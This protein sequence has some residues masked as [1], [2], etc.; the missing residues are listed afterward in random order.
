[1]SVYLGFM[2]GHCSNFAGFSILTFLLQQHKSSNVLKCWIQRSCC[3]L[4]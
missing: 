2:S 1:M 4:L 3:F